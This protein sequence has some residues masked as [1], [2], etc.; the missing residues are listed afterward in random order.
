MCFFMGQ[1]SRQTLTVTFLKHCAGPGV[2][3]SQHKEH[4]NFLGMGISVSEAPVGR[5]ARRHL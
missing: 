5:L 3:A 1:L 2:R 4:M